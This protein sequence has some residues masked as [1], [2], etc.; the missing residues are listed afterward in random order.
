[1][2]AKPISMLSTAE[3]KRATDLYEKAI[4]IEGLT[5]APTLLNLGYIE[6]IR[7]AGVTGN[8]ITVTATDAGPR[9]AIST[10]SG[11]YEIAEKTGCRFAYSTED[12]IRSKKDGKVC[13]IMGS[14]NA[15]MIDDDL[16]LLR[17]FYQL[18]IRVIQLAYA[19]Q[20]YVGSAGEDPDPGLSR[21]GRK[22]IKEM[23]RLGIL[24]DVSHCN[25]KTVMD[26]I[27]FSE[28]PVAITHA[29]PRGMVNRMRNKTDEQ[30]QAL[31]KKGGVFG[32]NA[33]S[34]I[35]AVKEGVRPSLEDFIDLIDYVVKLVGPDHVGFG[36]DLTPNWEY[37]R[38]DY[39]R[40]ASLYPSLAP[41]KFEERSAEG[42]DNIWG[43]K[44]IARG[45]VA[46]GYRSEDILKIMGG[47]FLELFQK[48]W[49]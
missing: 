26:A 14:Q 27:Q 15:R 43:V 49:A 48:V 7:K 45:L 30:I 10:I 23:N 12:V 8:H 4:V 24:V 6:E 46:R 32:L 34:P 1:M 5:Y 31:A 47:N 39:E 2:E 16:N 38:A 33:W 19:E 42:V 13:I 41:A 37:N 21:F 17:I 28:K 36:L 20:N 29:N 22:V 25:D 40:W 18:G 11:W 9:E 35:A 44:N 3:E